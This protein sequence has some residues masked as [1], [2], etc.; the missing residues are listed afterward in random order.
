VKSGCFLSETDWI[1]HRILVGLILNPIKRR[2][3]PPKGVYG[4]VE[5]MY[6]FVF[7]RKWE[8]TD[9]GQMMGI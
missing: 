3:Q 7:F 6:F 5:K 1:G 4:V 2:K 9:G 8:G